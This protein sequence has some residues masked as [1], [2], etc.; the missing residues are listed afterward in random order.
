MAASNAAVT[1]PPYGGT[2]YSLTLLASMLTLQLIGLPAL[3]LADAPILPLERKDA[4][5]LAVLALDGPTARDALAALLWPDVS[6]KTANISLRQRVFRLRKRSGHDV[7][8]TGERLA[9]LDDID[10]EAAIKHADAV[11]LPA[12][13]LLGGISYSDC[14]P[15]A[16]WVQRQ[17]EHWRARRRDARTL[18]AARHEAEGELARAIEITRQLVAEEPLSDH[19]QRRLMRLHYLRGDR[20]AAVQAFESFEQLLKDELSTRPDPETIEL[21]N[22]IE[23]SQPVAIA[24]RAVV[25]ASLRRPPRLVGRAAELNEL[26]H[27][28][29][30]GR[31]FVLLGEAGL[32]KT[33]LLQEFEGHQH[34]CFR[35][36]A[37]P[38]DGAVPFSLLA[39]LLRAVH[40][41]A[42]DAAMPADVGTRRELA[43]VMPELGAGVV[44]AGEGQRLMLQRAIESLLHQAAERGV[45]ALLVD[46]LHFADAASLEM[47]QGLIAS[48]RLGALHWGLA[49][50]PG[51]GGSACEALMRALEETQRLQRVTLQPLSATQIQALIESLN[52]AE[53][54]AARWAAPLLR[55]TGGNP[56]FVLETLKDMVLV[57]VPQDADCGLPQPIT[58]GALIERRLRQLTPPALALARVAAIAGVDFTIEL[59]EQ[60][61]KTPALALADA[62]SELEAA[63]VLQGAAFAHDLVYDAALRTVPAEI[64]RHTHAAVAEYLEQQKIDPARVAAHWQ[65]AGQAQRCAKALVEAALRVQSTGRVQEAFGFFCDAASAFSAAGAPAAAF[66]VLVDAQPAALSALQPDELRAWSERLLAAARGPAQRA[67][68]LCVQATVANQLGNAALALAAS[69][70]AIVLASAT[71]DSVTSLRA[72]RAAAVARLASGDAAAALAAIEPHID[73]AEQLDDVSARAE[74]LSDYGLLLER[75][76]RRGEAVALYDRA[77]QLARDGNNLIAA[78]IALANSAVSCVYLGQLD[79]ALVRNER[80]LQLASEMEADSISIAID[81]INRGGMLIE[82]GRFSE[83]LDL[84]GAALPVVER[85]EAVSWWLMATQHLAFLWA[86]LGQPGRARKVAARVRLPQEPVQQVLWHGLQLRIGRWTGTPIEP[87]AIEVRRGLTEV[88]LLTRQRLLLE[89]E[90][91][92]GLAAA[93]SSLRLRRIAS[94]ARAKQQFAFALTAEGLRIAALS[95]ADEAQMAAELASQWLNEHAKVDPYDVYLPELLLA[96]AVARKSIG[97][98]VTAADAI[99]QARRWTA[100]AVDRLPAS[101][102]D[103]FIRR[104]A[105]NQS[106]AAWRTG[107]TML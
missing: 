34:P 40:D 45:K 38:G 86:T 11:D 72:A 33:R 96:A 24:R 5:L 59:A 98:E 3:L 46:D 21:L 7:V 79:Q 87:H 68:G 10:L 77:A 41:A 32:G 27:A 78:Q 90:L 104:N 12:G 93:E 80:A 42:G 52:L 13:D 15:L 17:R 2:G 66:D 4:A 22:T 57:G 105:V 56:L 55:H 107:A 8:E 28:W 54:D 76:D 19:A 95:A 39:R 101:L 44:I 58:V 92:R 61:L 64:A 6:L 65:A 47:L 91:C 37:R 30:A 70:E 35:V 49:Q 16:D 84:L 23:H 20:A 102:R 81:K 69:E 82:A 29:A 71:G 99:A 26:D 18:A 75:T 88:P 63:Q 53:I 43:R 89:I 25:P 31:V 62:W 67:R 100:L 103:G 74:L 85:A 60:V 36:Q 94:E 1:D 9:L 14:G 48:E 83:A 97:D 50:R 51:E 73:A 106:V